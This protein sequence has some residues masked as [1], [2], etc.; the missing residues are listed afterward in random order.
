MKHFKTDQQKTS[1]LF[2]FLTPSLKY[3]VERIVINSALWFIISEYDE[4]CLS[5]SIDQIC[6]W[7]YVYVDKAL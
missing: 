3:W 6:L 7:F 2:E 5:C 4:V 1:Y